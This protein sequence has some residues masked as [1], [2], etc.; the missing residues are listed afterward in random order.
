MSEQAA[1]S[2]QTDVAE[3]AKE[4]SAK[5]IIEES[6]HDDLPDLVWHEWDGRSRMLL[7]RIYRYCVDRQGNHVHRY[8]YD[9]KPHDQMDFVPDQQ[10]VGV[11]WLIGEWATAR[12]KH[13]G[14]SP[15]A[16]LKNE[17]LE[18]TG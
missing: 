4:F 7:G 9:G 6:E 13:V 1:T 14:R 2:T 3:T 15:G 17:R 12:A 8:V 18:G 10:E 5:V 16:L 11:M